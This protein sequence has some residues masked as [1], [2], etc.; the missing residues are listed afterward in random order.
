MQ[1]ARDAG[2][3][4]PYPGEG[5]EVGRRGC[6]GKGKGVEGRRGKE[7]DVQGRGG[8]FKGGE[9]VGGC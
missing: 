2:R 1:M 9:G 7:R 4:L 5:V 3:V 8:M 6:G